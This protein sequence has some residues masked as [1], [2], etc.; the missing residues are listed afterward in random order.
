MKR[1]F[2]LD[3][4]G[5][6][7]FTAVLGN[8]LALSPNVDEADA[9]LVAGGDGSMVRAIQRYQDLHKPFI[10]LHAGYRGFLM[11]N[12]EPLSEIYQHLNEVQYETMW[13]LMAEGETSE[14]KIV[15]YGFNDVWVE[16]GTSQTL[17]MQV[18]VNGIQQSALLVGDGLLFSTPQ[19]ST[20]YNLALHGKA[21]PLG[22][23]VLQV[24]PMACVVEKTALG[25]IIFPD[26]AVVDVVF[27][28]IE[29]RPGLLFHDGLQSSIAPL[30]HLSVRKSDCQVQLGF[31]KEYSIH[32][33]VLAW[34]FQSS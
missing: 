13:M 31:I 30:R 24:T 20:G 18:S 6:P 3:H 4:S 12:A 7:R 9:I 16:R 27:L 5:D 26:T 10:G 17:R 25:S 11:N 19:G 2:L 1:Y 21:I 8:A 15:V 34:Q 28:Q 14:C 32:N 29:K 23:S 22:M 33:K